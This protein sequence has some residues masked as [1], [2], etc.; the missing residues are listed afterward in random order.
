[1]V[2]RGQ[3]QNPI[4]QEVFKK[5]IQTELGKLEGKTC[6]PAGAA[7]RRSEGGPGRDGKGKFIREQKEGHAD[8]AGDC[9]DESLVTKPHI[10][11]RGDDYRGIWGRQGSGGGTAGGG[12]KR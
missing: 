12:A 9:K 4:G 1:M 3:N 11:C 5:E 10:I 2:T 7:D 8:W 6:P